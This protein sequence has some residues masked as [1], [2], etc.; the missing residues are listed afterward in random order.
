MGNSTTADEVERLMAAELDAE[1]DYHEAMK[2]GD[3]SEA[4]RA[5]ETWINAADALTEYVAT[6][7]DLYRDSS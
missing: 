7:P 5:A 4:R 2:R 3:T 1:R 6:H